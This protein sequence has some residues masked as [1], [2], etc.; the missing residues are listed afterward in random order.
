MPG[1]ELDSAKIAHAPVDQHRLGT[2][3]RLLSE[4]RRITRV[5]SADCAKMLFGGKPILATHW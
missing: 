5:H 2:S 4:L 3:Q 1:S